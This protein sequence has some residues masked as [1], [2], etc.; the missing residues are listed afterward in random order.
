M[1][2]TRRVRRRHEFLRRASS[3]EEEEGIL[4]RG[5][6]RVYTRQSQISKKT[7]EGEGEG[8]EEGEEEEYY[9]T[10]HTTAHIS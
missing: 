4:E 5:T 9:C 6:K 8:E 2:R 7:E 1:P 3:P 10:P